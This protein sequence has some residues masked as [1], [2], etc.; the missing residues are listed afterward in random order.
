MLILNKLLTK[1][2]TFQKEKKSVVLPR[3]IDINF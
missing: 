3:V 2:F 1:M